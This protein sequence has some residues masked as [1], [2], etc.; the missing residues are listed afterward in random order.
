MTIILLIGTEPERMTRLRRTYDSLNR[1]GLTV[2]VFQPYKEPRGY[3]R[4]LTGIVRYL[5]ILLQLLLARADI[6]HF[7]NVPDVVGL[8]LLFKKGAMVYDVRS[9]WFSSV[10]ETLGSS[11]L[12]GLAGLIERFMTIKAHYVLTANT[13]LA[14]RARR[15]G[16][17]RVR[18]VPNYPPSDFQPNRSRQ[19]MRS[20]LNLNMSP[21]VL[22]LGK[23]AKLEGSELLKET[24]LTVSRNRRDVRFLIVG[25]GPRRESLEEFVDRHNL[26][27]KVI[28]TGWVK[29]DDV[30]NYIAASDVCLLPRLWTSFSQYTSPEN[31]LKVGEYLA[32]GRPVVVPRMGGFKEAQFPIIAVPP[33]KMG[34]AVLE[35]LENPREVSLSERATWEVSHKVLSEVYRDLGVIPNQTV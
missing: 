20:E 8:P 1:L 31:I 22:Y 28:F 16:S 30:P 6:Y 24:I 26:V 27:E 19:S 32:V 25:D 5:L 17:T 11:F 33:E 12:S 3:P 34:L 2:T 4:I 23:I 10:K 18:I 7:F 14:E 13:P 29:H 15:W 35:Y 21:T 9:P